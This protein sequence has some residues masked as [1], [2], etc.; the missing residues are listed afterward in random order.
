MKTTRI[1]LADDHTVVRKGLR[2][3]LESYPEFVVVADAADGRQ[4]VALVEE[5]RP[6][7][8]VMDVAMPV[9]NGIEAARQIGEHPDGHPRA[10]PAGIDELAVIVVIAEQQ[11]AEMRPRAFRVGPAD[12]DELLAIQRFGFAP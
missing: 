10:H 4:A 7:V 8:V 6:D 1:V 9:L 5:H 12:D 11:C 2:M 3:L